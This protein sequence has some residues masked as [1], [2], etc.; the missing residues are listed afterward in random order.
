MHGRKSLILQSNGIDVSPDHSIHWSGKI[1]QTF[2]FRWIWSTKR[3]PFC[4]EGQRRNASL[5][6][7]NARF[8]DLFSVLVSGRI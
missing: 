2:A 6:H 5:G 3:R 1:R 4:P 7:R 8:R